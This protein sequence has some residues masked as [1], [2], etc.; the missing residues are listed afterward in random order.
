M[1]ERSIS[2]LRHYATGILVR[3]EIK[4]KLPFELTLQNI[5]EDVHHCIV[6]WPETGID[7]KAAEIV[8]QR[9]R[10]RFPYSII[11]AIALP[12]MG[13][14]PPDFGINIFKIASN[15]FTIFGV[16]NSKLRLRLKNLNADISVDL[17]S[18]YNP[19]SAY[20]CTASGARIRIGFATPENDRVCNFQIAP[21]QDRSGVDRY[22]VLATYIG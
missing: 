14:S 11:T 9:L 2:F 6:C 20:C 10:N 21:N 1:F 8:F 7:V 16:P 18:V 5:W 4:R 15:E 12:G 13:A 17:S 22:R 3:S 19:L